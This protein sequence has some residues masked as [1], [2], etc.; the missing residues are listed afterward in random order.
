MMDF[1]A[2][3]RID[4]SEMRSHGWQVR[5]SR[6]GRKYSRF[7]SDRKYGGREVALGMARNFRDE[8]VARL[9]VRERSGAAG[10]LTRRN[11]SGVVGVSRI[12][13]RT[14]AATYEFW[15]ATWSPLPG[16]RRRVKFSIRRYGEDR[17]FELA[18]AARREAENG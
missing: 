3:S 8:L 6:R 9:P 15:Q 2:I 12:V 18:C 10:K 16:V 1:Y 4:L 7:F 17:A 13:V 5:L 14:T 11:I